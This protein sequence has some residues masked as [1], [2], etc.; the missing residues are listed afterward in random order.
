MPTRIM[1]KARLQVQGVYT[2]SRN[3]QNQIGSSDV[4]VVFTSTVAHKMLNA[5]SIKAKKSGAHMVHCTSSSA[6]ASNG[7]LKKHFA[8]AN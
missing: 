6:C 4:I 5:A 1:Q 3:F 8:A 2:V 7:A